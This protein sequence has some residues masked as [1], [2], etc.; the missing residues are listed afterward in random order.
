MHFVRTLVTFVIFSAGFVAFGYF[1]LVA[2]A[3]PG[4]GFEQAVA[5]MN[6]RRPRLAAVIPS[7]RV[8]AATENSAIVPDPL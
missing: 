1:G 5:A 6:E 3:G 8:G 2:L 4:D 7:P